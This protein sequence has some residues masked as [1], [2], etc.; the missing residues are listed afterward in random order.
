MLTPAQLEA[1]ERDG[2][3]TI[4][5]PL[6]TAELDAAEAAWDRLQVTGDEPYTEPAYL[7]TIAHPWFEAAAQQLLRASQVHLWWGLSPHSRPPRCVLCGLGSVPG[8]LRA[9]QS[10]SS[11]HPVVHSDC[12]T[13]RR[14]APSLT[15][16]RLCG[17]EARGVRTHA[18]C[19]CLTLR[20]YSQ[21]IACKPRSQ[22][23]AEGC[24]IDIQ[25]T[26]SDWEATPRRTRVE[27]WH[28]LNDVPI[29]KRYAKIVAHS[30]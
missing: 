11:S 4:D 7:S 2:A 8:D 30:H 27:L 12:L 23:W 13:P 5:G 29:V 16:Q 9:A 10:V 21:H 20:E 6:S 14:V 17:P 19:H 22:M 24:H 3:V 15:P 18:I 28:W 25:A 26:T 1:Y